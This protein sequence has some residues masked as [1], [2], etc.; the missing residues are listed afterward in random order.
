MTVHAQ[1]CKKVTDN[2]NLSPESIFFFGFLRI[3]KVEK[4]NDVWYT[5]LESRTEKQTIS[6]V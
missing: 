3:S 4:L 1:T 5:S 6:V 2:A